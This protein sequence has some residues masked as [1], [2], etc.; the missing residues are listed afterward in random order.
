MWNL[1]RLLT[2]PASA[3][4]GATTNQSNSDPQIRPMINQFDAMFQSSR[5]LSVM[6]LLENIC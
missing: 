6:S 1:V 4:R 2:V 3:T 5:I